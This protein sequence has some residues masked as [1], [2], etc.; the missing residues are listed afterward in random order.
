MATNIA[1]DSLLSDLFESGNSVIDSD[2]R[3]SDQLPLY[4]K[5]CHTLW[6]VVWTLKIAAFLRG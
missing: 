4:K 1:R 3:K 5:L 2:D 6:E